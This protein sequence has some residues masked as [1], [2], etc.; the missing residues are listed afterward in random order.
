M[1]IAQYSK[2]FAKIP[3]FEKIGEDYFGVVEI[4]SEGKVLESETLFSE[5]RP[6]SW[7]ATNDAITQITINHLR[8][9]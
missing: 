9:R 1:N 7:Q 3:T 5:P 8:V 6:T 2:G 4:H